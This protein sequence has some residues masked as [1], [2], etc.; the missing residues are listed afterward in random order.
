M[1]DRIKDFLLKGLVYYSIFIVVLIII[2]MFNITSE[3][4][5]NN[6]E[7]NQEKLI[8]IKER[9]NNLEESSCKNVLTEMTNVHEQTNYNEKIKL[10]ELYNQ[11]WDG[12]SFLQFYEEINKKC[13]ISED[14]MKELNI[15]NH[16]INSILYMEDIAPK[17]MMQY[18]INL[19]DLY[20]REIAEADSIG[21]SYNTSKES[22]LITIETVLDY[23]GG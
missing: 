12:P 4:E 1:K 8:N 19:K 9:I 5:L 14:E 2:N 10:S 22:E 20:V 18:E 13:N 11:Y 17:Y 3:I 16:L 6:K 15:P 23:I 7:S 21:L